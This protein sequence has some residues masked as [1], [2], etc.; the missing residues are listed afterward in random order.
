MSELKRRPADDPEPA[1]TEAAT[2]TDRVTSTGREPYAAHLD[3]PLAEG[4]P[5]PREVLDRFD[6]R[7]APAALAMTA[8]FFNTGEV[9]D[10]CEATPCTAPTG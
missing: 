4:E 10:T 7:R 5:T 2:R 6:P 3:K 1:I 9:L 8:Y